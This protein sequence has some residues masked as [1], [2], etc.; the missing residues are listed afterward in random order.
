MLAILGEIE[1]VTTSS[2]M[3]SSFMEYYISMKTKAARLSPFI[4]SVVKVANERR[5]RQEN[6]RV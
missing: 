4:S 5:R 6:V 2:S 1:N 3:S